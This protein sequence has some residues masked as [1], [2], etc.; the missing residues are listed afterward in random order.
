MNDYGNFQ[1]KRCILT[2]YKFQ[3]YRIKQLQKE[4]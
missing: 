3:K 2:S 4:Y 1:K